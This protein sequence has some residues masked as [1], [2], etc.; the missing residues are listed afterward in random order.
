MSIDKDSLKEGALYAYKDG[1][2]TEIQTDPDDTMKRVRILEDAYRAAVEVQR[3]MRKMLSGYR[4]DLHLVCSA[5]IELGASQP[6][7]EQSVKAFCTRL[8]G[9]RSDA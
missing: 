1:V 4:P 7:A 6:Q 9:E 5:L 2:L 3:N 8:F